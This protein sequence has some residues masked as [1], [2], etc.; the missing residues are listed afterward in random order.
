MLLR[1]LVHFHEDR[2]TSNMV[3][4]THP[5]G[6]GV[7]PLCRNGFDQLEYFRVR[8]KLH[9]HDQGMYRTPSYRLMEFAVVVSAACPK[10]LTLVASM[11]SKASEPLFSVFLMVVLIGARPTPLA[12]LY[13]SIATL[14]IALTCLTEFNFQMVGF[15]T[16]LLSNV[17]FATRGIYAKKVRI[18]SD[19][20]C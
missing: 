8:C 11:W 7:R 16:A 6:V 13:I 2:K 10:I 1:L 17:V 20:G 14:G 3:G 19:Y 18:S 4:S 12:T 5:D 15:L 9:T